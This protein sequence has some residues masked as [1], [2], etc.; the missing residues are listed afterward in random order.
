M[1]VA[2]NIPDS[3]L[4]FLYGI[5]A[6]VHPLLRKKGSLR[7]GDDLKNRSKLSRDKGGIRIYLFTN[8]QGITKGYLPSF[9]PN[10]KPI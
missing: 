9:A 10:I 3:G 2:K 1:V 5:L 8:S 6:N 7:Y 4:P